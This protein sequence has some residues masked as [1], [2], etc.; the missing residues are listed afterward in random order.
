MYT[1]FRG[2]LRLT[3]KVGGMLRELPDDVLITPVS[4]TSVYCII[5]TV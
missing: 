1:N 4:F 3:R 5:I 2:T